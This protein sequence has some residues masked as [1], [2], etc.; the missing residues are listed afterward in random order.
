MDVEQLNDILV[1]RLTKCFMMHLEVLQV[2]RHI[3]SRMKKGPL[4]TSMILQYISNSWRNNY[5]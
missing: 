5:L 3:Y 1:K 4:M 2:K